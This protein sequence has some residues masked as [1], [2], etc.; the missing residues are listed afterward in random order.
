MKDFKLSLLFCSLA[1]ALTGCGEN[2]LASNVSLGGSGSG[3]HKPNT[4]GNNG[5]SNPSTG[6]GGDKYEYVATI[7]AATENTCMGIQRNMR[8]IYQDTRL[9]IAANTLWKLSSSPLQ[10]EI[11]NN[12]PN[13][14]FELVPLCKQIDFQIG[15]MNVSPTQ[16]LKCAADQDS[17]QVLRPFE[18]RLYE[19]DLTFAETEEPII[20]NY[21]AFYSPELAKDKTVWTKCDSLKINIQMQKRLI[22]KVI[23]TEPQQTIT[24]VE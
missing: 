17:L 13:Y 8:F 10:I 2:L 4:G 16:S 5:T 1:L 20:V 7:P 6:D 22:E 3:S 21:Y 18:T 19:I 14:V 11:K 23:A 12:S 9:P 15:E 24:T